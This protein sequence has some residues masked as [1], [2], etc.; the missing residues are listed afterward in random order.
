MSN[1][2]SPVSVA[3]EF[4]KRALEGTHDAIENSVAV[5]TQFA[6]AMFGGF[7]PVRNASEQS[8]DLVRTGLDTYFEAIEAVVPAESG[9]EELHGMMHEQLD[10]LEESQLD[11]VDQFEANLEESTESTEQFLDEFLDALDEQITMLLETH[12]DLEAQTV[13]ALDDLEAGIE[14]L[15]TEFESQGEEIQA[16]LESQAE[17]IQ[18]QLEAVTDD[19]QEA[20]SE[21]AELSA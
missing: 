12:D 21:T 11:A 17:A 14:D 16:Q 3:F 19:I 18:E 1:Y 10:T 9:F 7:D 4:Q 8:T 5:Q 15:Q 13:D 2:S 6:D 20:A